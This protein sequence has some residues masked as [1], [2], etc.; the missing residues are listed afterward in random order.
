M[1]RVHSFAIGHSDVLEAG[2]MMRVSVRDK[3]FKEIALWIRCEKVVAFKP[4]KCS[5]LEML[6]SKLTARPTTTTIDRNEQ[7]FRGNEVT[8]HRMNQTSI[9]LSGW[10]LFERRP[11]Q[12]VHC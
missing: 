3:R 9:H 7:S 1:R 11:V 5:G 2:A 4:G 12:I 6:N 8:S 10:I